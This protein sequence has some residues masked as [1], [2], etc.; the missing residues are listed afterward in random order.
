MRVLALLGIR[1]SRASH[2]SG[3]VKALGGADG[4]RDDALR[5]E[6]ADMAK[7][8]RTMNCH[9]D[10]VF[11]V[12]SDAWLYPA[13]VVGASRMRDVDEATTGPGGRVAG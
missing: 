7:N 2:A 13:W 10:D 11:R 12:L 3:R 5:R 1:A 9:P 4:W 8:V 6:E